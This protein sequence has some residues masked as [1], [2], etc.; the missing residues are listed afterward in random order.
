MLSAYGHGTVRDFYRAI[1]TSYDTGPRFTQSHAK[2][3]HVYGRLLLRE[4]RFKPGSSRNTYLGLLSLLIFIHKFWHN[5]FNQNPLIDRLPLAIL[6]YHYLESLRPCLVLSDEDWCL[7]WY[8][9]PCN[10]FKDDRTLKN[11]FNHGFKNFKIYNI[12]PKKIHL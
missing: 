8:G 6:K 4:V 1:R 9:T 7:R 5:N 2:L 11:D 10:I 3:R 12:C